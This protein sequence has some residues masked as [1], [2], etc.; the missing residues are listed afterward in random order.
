MSKEE[1]I[2]GLKAAV[3]KGESLNKAMVSFY[4]SGYSKQDIED[5][6]RALESPQISQ[7]RPAAQPSTRPA[8]PQPK[9]VTEQKEAEKSTF[10]APEP[11][12]SPEENLSQEYPPLQQPQTIQKVSGYGV[13]PSPLG[14]AVVFILVFFLLFLIGILISVFLFKD[15]LATFFNSFIG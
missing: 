3:A 1:I 5:A 4:N 9:V 6:A 2:E 8:A 13:K 11:E 7:P 12:Y 10:N 15:K 14:A